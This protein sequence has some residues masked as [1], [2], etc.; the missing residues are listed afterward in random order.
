MN[1]TML[2]VLLFLNQ[3]HSING[4]K[5]DLE[6]S[7]PDFLSLKLTRPD[8]GRQ[9]ELTDRMNPFYLCGDFDDEKGP[10]CAVFLQRKQQVN[11]VI[12]VFSPSRWEPV[13]IYDSNELHG[14]A[15]LHGWK[16]CYWTTCGQA[17]RS[18][19]ADYQ[20]IK[21]LPYGK[22]S[23]ILHYGGAADLWYWKDGKFIKAKWA[24]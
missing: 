22:D 8:I 17:V 1:I 21:E 15:A 6:L 3:L 4:K 19:N 2:I 18:G 13:K 12:L 5:H 24:E 7:I 14:H 20:R 16:V 11:D 10:E 9:Y 23:I